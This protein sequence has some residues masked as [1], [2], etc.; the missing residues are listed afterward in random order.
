MLRILYSN[1][2]QLPP[3]DVRSQR[4]SRRVFGTLQSDKPSSNTET[5]KKNCTLNSA[6]INLATL[7]HDVMVNNSNTVSLKRVRSVRRM[8][9]TVP[10]YQ[11]ASGTRSQSVDQDQLRHAVATAHP[12]THCRLTGGPSGIPALESHLTRSFSICLA[13]AHDKD[14]DSLMHSVISRFFPAKSSFS[15]P[16]LKM[17]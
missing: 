6:V 3:P 10:S 17:H 1:R 16:T 15:T 9:T 11:V 14:S 12:D 5:L 4:T 2:R 7:R 13:R 8:L